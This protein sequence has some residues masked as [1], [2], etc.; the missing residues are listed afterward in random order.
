MAWSR[1]NTGIC[2][3]YLVQLL[4][5]ILGLLALAGCG[6]DK[7]TNNKPLSELVIDTLWVLEDARIQSDNPGGTYGTDST[8]STSS[9]VFTKYCFVSGR[10]PRFDCQ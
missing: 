3:P 2:K 8:F 1:P 4:V 7:A 9:G 6:E 5:G 10:A